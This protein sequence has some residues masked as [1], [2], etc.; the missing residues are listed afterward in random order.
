MHLFFS[1]NK[2]GSRCLLLLVQWLECV[3]ARISFFSPFLHGHKINLT[4]S[5]ILSAFKAGR[6]GKGGN[7]NS[8]IFFYQENFHYQTLSL[9]RTL[10]HLSLQKMLVKWLFSLLTYQGEGQCNWQWLL[11]LLTAVIC[12]KTTDIL[13][14]LG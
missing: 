1:H 6:M 9:A 5:S 11:G 13:W 3:R 14:A 12:N 4:T 8:V 7:A 2:C 10:I